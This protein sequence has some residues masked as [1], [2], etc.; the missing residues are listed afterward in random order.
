MSRHRRVLVVGNYLATNGS[1]TVT[2]AYLETLF[3]LPLGL[4]LS[5]AARY[6]SYSQT[7]DVVTWKVGGAWQP[8]PDLRLRVTRSRDIRAPNLQELFAA[9]TRNT[10]SLFDPWQNANSVRFTQTVAGNL[11]LEP[12]EADTLGVGAIF[13]PSFLPGQ[14]S[15]QLPD[16]ARPRHRHRGQ[17][18][19]Q[20]G[21]DCVGSARQ[22]RDPC[23]GDALYR[24]FG[25]ER[26]RSAHRHRW[27]E[28]AGRPA[29]LDLSCHAR[30]QLG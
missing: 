16:P 28:H 6:T 30:L 22:Y 24:G 1:Y 20:P 25:I 3:K 9:G 12:E 27:R 14:Q 23:R 5:G 2:E 10:N 29:E 17:L 15:V 19:L 26:H 21:F 18:S 11:A 8:I 4:E 7:G 13:R